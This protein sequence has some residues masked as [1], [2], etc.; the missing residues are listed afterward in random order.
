MGDQTCLPSNQL[1]LVTATG[2]RKICLKKRKETVEEGVPE[3]VSQEIIKENNNPLFS[4][5]QKIQ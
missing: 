2:R 1:K 4:M 5:E 3:L